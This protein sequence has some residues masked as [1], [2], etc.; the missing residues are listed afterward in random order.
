MLSQVESLKLPIL[1]VAKD[2][3]VIYGP[4]SPSKLTVISECSSE[5]DMCN[6]MFV[7]LEENQL[8]GAEPVNPSSIASSSSSN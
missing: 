7:P 3:H 5:L 1:G 2:G 8:K 6:G 4:Y